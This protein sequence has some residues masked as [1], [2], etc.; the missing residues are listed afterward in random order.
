MYG[1][2]LLGYDA[3]LERPYAQRADE[4]A[5]FESWCELNDRDPSDPFNWDLF[6]EER[7]DI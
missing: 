1:N 3:W 6:D 5:A 2:S 7:W 4:E